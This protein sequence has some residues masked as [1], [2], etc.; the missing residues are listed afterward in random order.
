[1]LLRL[2]DA[3]ADEVEDVRRLLDEHRIDFYETEAG[4]WG[5]SVAA[6]WLRDETRLE[7]ARRLIDDYEQRRSRRVRDEFAAERAA[8]RAETHWR[9]LLR[10]P[11]TVIVYLAIIAG[12][13]Y[14]TIAPFFNTF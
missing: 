7:E 6:I 5:F 1:M 4:R 13:L 14:L 9:R 2:N 11:I 10:R 8:G 3:P 12:I